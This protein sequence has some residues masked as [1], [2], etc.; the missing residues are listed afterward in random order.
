MLP[1]IIY[2]HSHDT[3]R[4][5][6]P[7]G[8]N[9][10]T[11]N[12]QKL[13][14]Q[15][16]TF[17]QAFCAAPTCSPSRAALLTGQSPHN[18]GMLG[19]VHRGF[20]LYDMKQHLIHTLHA[21]GYTSAI[22]GIQ[23]VAKDAE[24]IGYHKVMPREMGPVV[25]KN[26][27]DF[28]KD[29]PDQPFFLNCGFSE[30]HR[31]FPPAAPECDARW[32][33]PPAPL[34]DTPQTR[35]DMADYCTMARTL[36]YSIGNILATLE[37]TGLAENTLVIYTTDHGVAFPGMKCNLTDHGMGVS[38][39]MRGPGGFS[40]NP[41]NVCD[42]MVSHIDVFPT[43][44]DLLGIDRPAWLQGKSMLPLVQGEASEI[45][46]EIY[47]E[48]SYH[49]AYE[50]KR[51]VR[52]NRWKYIKRFDDYDRVVL[53]N[54][55]PS[56]SKESWLESGWRDLPREKELLFDLAFDPNEANNLA[57]EP[58]VQ[59]VLSDMRN[60]LDAWMKRTDDPLLSGSVPQPEGARITPHDALDAGGRRA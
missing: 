41:G 4:Y 21:A 49:A 9:V 50:P 11:P 60:R 51:A 19:L 20:D 40:D 30:T 47:S 24:S 59:D 37:R 33:R 17:R 54:C 58:R 3:G 39:I 23:H 6:S 13:A 35:S 7:Y 12:L 44:C 2:L 45:N 55:D 48:V 1:N 29:A 32:M 28:L 36:D 10:P 5:I 15:G 16:T 8:Y 34:P 56:P 46:D 43:I 18:S 52:T 31:Q 22:S 53:P 25:A 57:G 38:L 27:C 26:A 14:E 42:A